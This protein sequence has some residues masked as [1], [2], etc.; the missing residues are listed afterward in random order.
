MLL[1]SE[2]YSLVVGQTLDIVVTYQ[3]GHHINTVTSDSVF[4][5]LDP[6]IVHVDEEGNISGLRKGRTTLIINYNGVE[7]RATIDVY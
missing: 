2:D 3:I 7:A 6:S 5:V 4:N 1:D